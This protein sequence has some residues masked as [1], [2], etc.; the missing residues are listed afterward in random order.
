[1]NMTSELVLSVELVDLFSQQR[2]G[3]F[4]WESFTELVLNTPKAQGTQGRLILLGLFPV[5]LVSL[6][7]NELSKPV[8]PAVKM[9]PVA[10]T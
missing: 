3:F 2:E 9:M 10:H 6:F 1:M 7:S 4:I 8:L 5:G